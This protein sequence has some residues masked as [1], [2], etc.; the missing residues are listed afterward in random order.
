M[1]ISNLLKVFVACS[2][3]GYAGV[4]SLQAQTIG[5]QEL[6]QIKESSFQERQH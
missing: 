4:G 6:Q 5:A 1:K 3:M 2:V